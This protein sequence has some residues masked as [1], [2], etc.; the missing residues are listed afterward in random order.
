M[1]IKYEITRRRMA[2][3]HLLYTTLH[4]THEGCVR[5]GAV[6]QSTLITKTKTK[7]KNESAN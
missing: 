4:N 6:D 3:Q 7:T 1:E 2:D 5:N